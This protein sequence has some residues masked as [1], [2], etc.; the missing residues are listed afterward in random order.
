MF[1]KKDKTIRKLLNLEAE[2]ADLAA[3]ASVL[4]WDQETYMPERGIDGR[5]N[6]LATIEEL[7]H[8]KFTRKYT[9]KLIE[10]LEDK[11]Q[12]VRFSDYDRALVRET[13]RDYENAVKLPARF[14][15]ERVELTSKAMEV[16]KK[17]RTEKKFSVFAPYLSRM[18]ETKRKEADYLGYRQFP[19]DALLD[20]YE[21]G[22]TQTGL[23]A[24]FSELKRSSLGVLEKIN[25]ADVKP[26]TGFLKLYYPVE[27][28]LEFS[29][30][31]IESM[32]F[33]FSAG[34]LDK[35]PH[36]FT[37]SF[38]PNDVRITTRIDERFL[39]ECISGCIHET[40][41]GLYEQGVDVGLARTRLAT[42]SSWGFHESQSR[43]WENYV[44]KSP[45]FWR[46]W[47]GKLRET[48]PENLSNISDDEFILAMNEVK[49]SLIR[50]EADE[51]TY[52][53][54]VILR[55]EI[56]KSLING[57]LEVKEVPTAWNE[58]MMDYLG[59]VPE[60]DSVGCLQDIHWSAGD[61]GYFPTY[62]LGNLYAAQIYHK[63][64]EDYPDLEERLSNGD[65]VFI[66]KWLADK[67]H[68]WGKTYLPQDLIGMVTGETLNLRYFDDYLKSKFGRLYSF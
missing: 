66:R 18:I 58:R 10:K 55:F 60:N 39:P 44:G 54:H 20:L 64:M 65:L 7:Y 25:Q 6:S 50:T 4:M 21:P 35:S 17:A 30:K 52:N 22:V 15:R 57:G 26:N 49:P 53:L 61:I 38:H 46:F 11:I 27:K 1:Y 41:H 47:F 42:G 37:A 5:A 34:R 32:G 48:F 31:V 14:V 12:D 24:V 28:Q 59:I 62:S 19:Y 3:A 68:V 2:L 51:V 63:L 40:G 33:D 43:L 67:I 23:E 36:P 16:W 56:E 29:R 9:G 13:K 45:A 8:K